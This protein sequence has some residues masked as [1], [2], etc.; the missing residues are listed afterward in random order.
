MSQRVDLICTHCQKKIGTTKLVVLLG[1]GSHETRVEPEAEDLVYHR[2]VHSN[3]CAE[4]HQYRARLD[5]VRA[6]P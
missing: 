1:P 3:V 4:L 5:E 2:K 6:R